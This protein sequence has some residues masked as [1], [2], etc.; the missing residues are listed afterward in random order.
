MTFD[1]TF[2]A[3]HRAAEATCG[4]RLF[5]VTVLDR[6]AGLARRAYSSHP[7][8]YPVTGTKPMR[9]DPWSDLVI[10]EHKSFV[11]NSTPEFALY[12]SDHALINA[13]GC[14]SALNIPVVDAGQV[15]GTVNILDAEGHF[16]PDRVATLE[17]LVQTHH[18][19]LLAAFA[20]V[21]METPA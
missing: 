13:L 10:G 11:A 17:A 19:A 21:P 5:T 3:L 20:Q 15:L 18:A 8:D 2:S 16:T 1:D 12:F 14:H 6:K 9:D 7:V 4:A